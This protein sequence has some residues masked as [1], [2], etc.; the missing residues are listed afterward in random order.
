MIHHVIPKHEWKQRFGSLVG[1]NAPDNLV[2]LT[3][4]Q[5]VQAHQLLFEI[6]GNQYDRIAW[7]T[8]S[9]QIG[10]EEAQRRA[11]SKHWSGRKHAEGSKLKQS[12]AKVGNKNALGTRRSIECKQELSKLKKGLSCGVVSCPCCGKFGRG[13]VMKRWHF[14][15]CRNG[16]IK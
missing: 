10:H 2:S 6:N 8:L 15:N 4:E 1:I 5:H 14:D 3:T 9:G 12:L 7:Q 13:N 11:T 16:S